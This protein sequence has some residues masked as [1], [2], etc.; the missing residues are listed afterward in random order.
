M[1]PHHPQHFHVDNNKS[2][3]LPDQAG[4]QPPGKFCWYWRI[5]I[6][7]IGFSGIHNIPFYSGTIFQRGLAFAL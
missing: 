3:K 1:F 2:D 7:F 5:I 4:P 6:L